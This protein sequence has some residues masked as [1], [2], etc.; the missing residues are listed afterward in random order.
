M[1]VRDIQYIGKTCYNQQ[2]YAHSILS[3]KRKKTET[4]GV[5][6]AQVPPLPD[7]SCRGLAKKNYFQDN[8]IKPGI[9]WKDYILEYGAV[10]EPCVRNTEV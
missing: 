7:T 6:T 4:G 8:S 1:A 3:V 5:M 10:I 9:T 2:V